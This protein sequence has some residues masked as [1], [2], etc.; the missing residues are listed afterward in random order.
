MNIDY[1]RIRSRTLICLSFIHNTMV[2]LPFA[3]TLTYQ[4]IWLADEFD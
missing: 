3:R 4:F 2:K 1:S